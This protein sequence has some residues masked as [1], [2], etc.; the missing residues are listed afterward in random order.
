MYQWVERRQQAQWT[1]QDGDRTSGQM[2]TSGGTDR[3]VTDGRLA[4]WKHEEVLLPAAPLSAPRTRPPV[5]SE[6]ESWCAETSLRDYYGESKEGGTTLG[7]SARYAPH[8]VQGIYMYTC[9]VL[10]PIVVSGASPGPPRLTA[11]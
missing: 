11:T 8:H 5:S 10:V 7:S 3:W 9:W 2:E 1:E 4:R 6:G